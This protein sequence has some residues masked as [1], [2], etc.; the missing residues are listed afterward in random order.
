MAFGQI[1]DGAPVI[2]KQWVPIRV[3]PKRFQGSIARVVKFLV[4]PWWQP[5]SQGFFEPKPPA[6]FLLTPTRRVQVRADHVDHALLQLHVRLRQASYNPL[7]LRS[8]QNRVTEDK[9]SIG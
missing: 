4:A 3:A 2:R 5:V 6:Q 7:S 9:V 1:F 8:R